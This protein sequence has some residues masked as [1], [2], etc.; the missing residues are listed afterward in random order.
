[1]LI[2]QLKILNIHMNLI[3]SFKRR[4]KQTHHRSFVQDPDRSVSSVRL[5]KERRE[6]NVNSLKKKKGNTLITFSWKETNLPSF[7]FPKNKKKGALMTF[8]ESK[9]KKKN[10]LTFS[11]VQEPFV[12]LRPFVQA[13]FIKKKKKRG[14]KKK[15]RKRKEKDKKRKRTN[16]HFRSFRNRSFGFTR[17][18]RL[19]F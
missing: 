12:R 9:K 15:K 3:I 8:P 11:F 10:E 17:S 5:D 19:H 16:L 14:V 4:T 2:N 13:P 1:M 7:V 18:S 6:E